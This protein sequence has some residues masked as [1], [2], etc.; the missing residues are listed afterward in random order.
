M[1]INWVFHVYFMLFFLVFGCVLL[2]K[3]RRQRTGWQL[4]TRTR[5]YVFQERGTTRHL[6]YLK[7]F[8]LLGASVINDPGEMM[9]GRCW[10]RDVLFFNWFSQLGSNLEAVRGGFAC[11]LIP[12]TQS[13]LRFLSFHKELDRFVDVS[14]QTLMVLDTEGFHDSYRLL[15]NNRKQADGTFGEELR[16]FL[17]EEGPFWL[18]QDK[19]ML[20][21][22]WPGMW[23]P[24]LFDEN[25]ERLG[26]LLKLLGEIKKK[27]SGD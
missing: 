7:R 20:L 22:A 3:A 18:E 4:L 23:E 16:A 13:N 27:R 8:R 6:P 2:W 26:R 10:D 9:A 21:I 1:E 25:V 19:D 14:G 11:A 24:H 12:C 17:V 5:N 15:C